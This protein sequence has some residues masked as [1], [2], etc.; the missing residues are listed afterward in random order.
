MVFIN[1][2][3]QERAVDMPSDTP[4]LWALRDYLGLT[5]TKFG[6]GVAQCGACTVHVN[7]SP[8]RSCVTPLSAVVGKNVTTIEGLSA[9]GD[10]PLQKAF[11]A[12]N[13]FQCGYCTPGQIMQA[14]A[15]LAKN[16]K[17]TRPQIASHMAGH[18][19]RCGCYN[20]IVTA[21]ER[22]AQEA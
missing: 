12:D 19:C 7:G 22:A 20:Q 13:A 9:R 4:L 6:C 15:L 18:V 14:A 10:H 11:L 8:T 2:N 5:G 21:V 3:R 17:P 16:K 1:V